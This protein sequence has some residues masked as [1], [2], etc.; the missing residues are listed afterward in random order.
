MHETKGSLG[1]KLLRSVGPGFVTGAADDDPSG[2]ATYSQTGALLGYTQLWLVPYALPFMIAIQEMCGRIGAVTGKGLAGVMRHEYSRTLLWSA[3]GLLVVANT[4]NIGADLGAM[5]SAVELLVPIPAVV[6]LAAITFLTLALQ[7]LVP[8]PSYANFL[9]YLTL[10]LLSYIAAAFFVRQDWGLVLS[11]V[12]IPHIAFSRAYLLNIAA[13]LGTTISPY[14]F[15]WQADEEVEEEVEGKRLREIGVGTPK[16]SARFM[17]TMR[18]DTA[19]GMFFSQFVTFFI[20]ITAAAT[21]HGAEIRTA[22]DAA[23][24]LQPLGGDLA[25][26]LFSLGILSTGLLAVPVLSGSAAFAVAEAA[27]WRVGLE[28]KF[29]KARMF[30]GVIVVSTLIGILVNFLGIG[31]ITLLYYS[32][33]LNGV[34]APPLMLII[35]LIA[36]NK[37]IM[38][39]RVNGLVGNMLGLLIT[40]VMGAVAIA[41]IWSFL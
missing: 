37:R 3:V 22:A 21:M 28:K 15:F 16:I 5:A 14:L 1:Q 4:I 8:Y 18:F 41:L 27:H 24:A 20:I 7:V 19:L 6:S 40:A 12:S 33:A 9:K 29:D 13:V 25:F 23:R 30:Y 31:P 10:A 35:I 39:G 36:N 2:I 32:A 38:G 17:R 11:S 26:L 34:L